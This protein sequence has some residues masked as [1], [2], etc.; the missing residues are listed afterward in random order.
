MIVLAFEFKAILALAN[1]KLVGDA[2]TIVLSSNKLSLLEDISLT[3]L[4]K[5]A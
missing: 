3:L 4:G 5:N 1:A 2:F